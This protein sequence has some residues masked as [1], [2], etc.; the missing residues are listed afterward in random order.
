[1]D[2]LDRSI[3]A[4]WPLI[5]NTSQLLRRLPQ[6]GSH[7]KREIYH[8]AVSFVCRS[9]TWIIQT[10][11]ISDTSTRN[12]DLALVFFGLKLERVINQYK[13][14]LVLRSDEELSL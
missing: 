3:L 2:Y 10:T 5:T 6:S 8:S 12:D 13:I 1:M 4:C 7:I 14:S 11:S 9:N